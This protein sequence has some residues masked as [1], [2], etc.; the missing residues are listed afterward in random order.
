MKVKESSLMIMLLL[1]IGATMLIMGWGMLFYALLIV[2]IAAAALGIIDLCDRQWIPGLIKTIVGVALALVTWYA[3]DIVLYVFA[4]LLIAYGI[5]QIILSV[6]GNKNGLL[7]A[8]LV[9]AL[10]I[11]AGVM[12]I[13]FMVGAVEVMTTIFAIVLL[14]AGAFLLIKDHILAK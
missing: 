4:A 6:K 14:V 11:A 10:C 2:G 9:P 7:M 5:Y 8:L 3:S 13:I 1:T 12:L